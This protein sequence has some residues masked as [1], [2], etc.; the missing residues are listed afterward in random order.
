[1]MRRE[2][3]INIASIVLAVVFGALMGSIVGEVLGSNFPVLREHIT[4]GIQTTTVD[5]N[6]L[7][8]PFGFQ[9]KLNLGSALGIFLALLLVLRRR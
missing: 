3:Q 1:M 4:I 6:V 2:S 9:A 5:L 8:F 7:S